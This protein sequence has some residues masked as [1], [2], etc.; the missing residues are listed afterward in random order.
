MSIFKSAEA[1]AAYR[2]AYDCSLR[3]W[4][5]G[6]DCFYV[7]TKFGSTH[8]IACGPP[9]G[10]PVLL[11]SAMSFSATMWYATVPAL[12]SEFRCYAADFPSDMG[13]SANSN[14]PARLADCAAWLSGLLDGL[15]IDCCA[16]V[17]ASY[18]GFLALNYA[19]AEPAR[20]SRVLVCSPAAGFIAL[21]KSMFLR[22]FLSFLLPGRSASERIMNWIFEDRLPLDHPVIRQLMVGIQCL[23]PH[24][25]VY[26]RV[27]TDSELAR[28]QSPLYLLL[29][30]K[31]VCYNPKSAAQRARRVMKNATVEIVPHAGHLVVMECPEIVNPRI[32]AFLRK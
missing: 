5:A 19:T 17:G 3:L 22:L 27:F 20:V 29:G 28:I 6:H 24:L 31:E 2:S 16:L 7:A 9:D 8:V 11:L 15:A 12:S 25:R 13:L 23:K 30:E 4:P 10:K 26:P 32:A 14:P 18:G 1:E 21:R